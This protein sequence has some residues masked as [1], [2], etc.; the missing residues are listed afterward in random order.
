MS[1]F[2]EEPPAPWMRRSTKVALVLLGTAGVVG[3]ATAWDAWQRARVRDDTAVNP[4]QPPV[5]P[6]SG[7]REYANNTYVPGAGYYHAP[8]FAW[9]PFAW[10]FHNPARGYFAGGQWHGS[11]LAADVASSRPSQPAVLAAAAAQRASQENAQRQARSTGFV[12]PAGRGP[13][14]GSPS[15]SPAPSSKPTTMRGGFGSS[16]RGGSS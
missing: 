13:A 16:S 3:A 1:A 6:V 14:Y 11:P 15:S 7:D 12:S 4:V 10:N 2:R 8:F 9:F 5:A